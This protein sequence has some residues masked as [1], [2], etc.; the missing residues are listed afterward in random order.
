MRAQVAPRAVGVLLGLT[1]TLNPFQSHPSF[2]QVAGLPLAEQVARLRDPE[3]RRRLLA[4]APA[5]A[6]AMFGAGFDRIFALRL[7]A[8][9]ARLVLERRF[10]YM[11]AMQAGDIVEVPL[12]D[13]VAARKTLTDK[14]LDRYESFFLP[15]SSP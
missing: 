6:F 3:L 1:A 12:A 14:F 4:E 9:A 2:Q 10:G 7:G 8:R 15:I 13:A 11:A 5:P